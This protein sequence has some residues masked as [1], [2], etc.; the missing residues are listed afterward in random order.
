L[1]LVEGR[2]LRE[3]RFSVVEKREGERKKEHLFRGGQ[4]IFPN[5]AF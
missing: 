4:L 3:E 5:G 2:M 1:Y